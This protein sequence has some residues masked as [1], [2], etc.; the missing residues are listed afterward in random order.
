MHGKMSLFSARTKQ[1]E[2]FFLFV[3]NLETSHEELWDAG[4]VLFL[5]MVIQLRSI[6]YFLYT[7]IQSFLLKIA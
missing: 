7:S 5:V 1:T 6:I 4:N 2:S 3:E